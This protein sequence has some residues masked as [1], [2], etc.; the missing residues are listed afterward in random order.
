[1]TADF[2]PEL[3][4]LILDHLQLIGSS[5]LR[6]CA[7]V[8][9]SWQYPSSSR[10]FALITLV[11]TPD[12]I[13]SFFAVADTSL[14]PLADFIRKLRLEEEEDAE[15]GVVRPIRALERLR[16]VQTLSLVMT[17]SALERARD[18]LSTTF[19]AVHTLTFHAYRPDSMRPILAVISDFP[20]LEKLVIVRAS[21]GFF[22]THAFPPDYVFPPRLRAVFITHKIEAFF[23]QIVS[24]NTIP[25]FASITWPEFGGWPHAGSAMGTYFSCAGAAL[26]HLRLC[27][28]FR[29]PFS[30]AVEAAALRHCT[31]L[32]SLYI[33]STRDR[34][35]HTI[36]LSALPHLRAPELALITLAPPYGRSIVRGADLVS[37]T[38][39][40]IHLDD[41]DTWRGIDKALSGAL[42]AGLETL[43][44][45]LGGKAW[46]GPCLVRHMPLCAARGILVLN[47]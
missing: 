45:A 37:D 4:H 17:D 1:M 11:V 5:S 38:D 25:Q 16:R 12:A 3:V 2:P 34:R 47:H 35:P 24:L 7:L 27:P 21:A 19:P 23:L 36:L 9:K 31:G 6:Q 41:P 8:C 32:R 14:L 30:L 22:A 43:D 26:R 18:W 46:L 39:A 33:G 29:Q 10:L 13:D 28:G 20:A 44:V 42:F 15:G 40:D